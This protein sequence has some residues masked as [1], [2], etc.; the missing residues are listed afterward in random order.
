MKKKY[1]I[2]AAIAFVLVLA[3]VVI[4]D[5]TLLIKVEPGPDEPPFMFY[6]IIARF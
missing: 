1:L 4:N 3:L 2:L 5:P 6:R